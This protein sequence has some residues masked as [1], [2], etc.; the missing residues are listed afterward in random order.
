MMVVAYCSGQVLKRGVQ[1]LINN[2]ESKSS[3]FSA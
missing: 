1:E 2:V 3:R